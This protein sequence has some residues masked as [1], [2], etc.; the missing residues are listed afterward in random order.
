MLIYDIL[1]FIVFNC[2]M[3]DSLISRRFLLW[4]FAPQLRDI[5]EYSEEE[6]SDIMLI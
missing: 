6:E 1:M 2:S 3:L 4:F 5:S